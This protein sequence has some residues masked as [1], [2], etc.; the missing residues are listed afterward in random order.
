MD[1]TQTKSEGL[2]REFDL[3][4]SSK[5]IEEKLE[6]RLMKLG[7]SLKVD[8][9]RPGKVPLPI[10]KQ[11]YESNVKSE[12]LEQALQD[13]TRQIIDQHKLRVALQPE[14]TIKDDHN[15]EGL[16]GGVVIELLP[17]IEKIDLS[18]IKLEQLV[19][20]VDD[21][22]VE[23]ALENIR[24]NHAALKPADE[25][26]R[27][28]KGHVVHLAFKG[29][30]EGKA[31][32]GGSSEGMDLELGSET[33]IPGFEENLVGL[34]AG[35]KKEFDI[36]FPEEYQ[37]KDLAGKTAHFAIEIKE[38]KEKVVPEL[39]LEFAQKFEKSSIDDLKKSVWEQLAE[40]HNH[41]SFLDAKRTIMD[42]FAENFTFDV[43]QGLVELE[44]KSI[45]E[46]LQREKSQTSDGKKKGKKD[47][48]EDDEQELKKQYRQIAERRV[49]LGLLLAEIGREHN[50]VVSQ[51]VFER[52][53]MREAMKYPG[54]ERKVIDYYHS[55]KQAQAA[56]R[57]PLFEDRVIELILEKA[58]VHKKEVLF[59]ELKKRFYEITEEDE[60]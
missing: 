8:G 58:T 7:Q 29:T 9:F 13:G 5:E 34:K 54:M 44:F 23:E 43:P 30:L 55:N 52:A 37:A 56:L 33:F 57:A 50:I 48:A 18:K 22:E 45:W 28:K 32:A 59:A 3:V 14:V 27:A 2:I 53:L 19:S 46:Q 10:L 42:Q 40:N 4:F 47:P 38:I 16:R 49:R 41:M 39:T 25:K 24:K 31:I 1:I 20:Q 6:Q 21:N 36:N 51:K 11:R 15:S 60:V 26:T 35:E 17:D 12:V